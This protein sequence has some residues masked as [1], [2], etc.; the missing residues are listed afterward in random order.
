[1][2][3]RNGNYVEGMNRNQGILLPDTLDDYVGED[4]PVRFIDAFVDGLDMKELGFKHSEPSEEGRPPYDP[5]DMLK[6]YVYGYLNQVRS[7]RK[8]LRKS[9]RQSLVSWACNKGFERS[10]AVVRGT[11]PMG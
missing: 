6:L 4:N 8:L 3:M 9:E 5:R 1:M 2:T 11:F 7:S 10:S